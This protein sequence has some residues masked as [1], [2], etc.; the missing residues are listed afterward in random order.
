VN[1][2]DL[3]NESLKIPRTCLKE[4]IFETNVF[5]LALSADETCLLVDWT[6]LDSCR[7]YSFEMKSEYSN[8]W[9]SAP[10]VW[11]T[12]TSRKGLVFF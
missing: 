8:T 10:Y 1:A 4:Q 7:K 3:T 11:E 9:R 2:A 6:S 12:F 5:S